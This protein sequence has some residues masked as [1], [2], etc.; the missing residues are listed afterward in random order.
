VRVLLVITD[1]PYYAG[2]GF[3][4]AWTQTLERHGCEVERLSGIPPQWALDGPPADRWQLA[5][6]HVL[7][8]EVA[9]F[10]PTMQLASLLESA[11]VPLLNRLRSIVT[12]ADKLATHAAWAAHDLPQPATVPLDGI[13]RWPRPGRR[14]VLK[15]ALGDGARHIAL[16]G[17]LDEARAIAAAWRADERRGGERRGR[18]L[19]QEWIEEPTC[20]R[21]YATPNRTSLA[22][23]KDRRPGALVTHGTVYPRV[24]T[25]PRA[26]AD[27]ARRMVATLGGGLMGVDVLTD[28]DGRHWALEAN[29]P[30]G[31]DITDRGQANF[32]AAAALDRIRP[33]V[34]GATDTRAFVALAA[35]SIRNRR[36]R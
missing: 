12:S 11:R 25:P 7:V 18:A 34:S 26:M 3:A 36:R 27:L 6:P 24:H 23:E 2:T 14:M 9:A 35:G 15:P 1:S 16:V 22:Y 10:A 5:I 20:T 21:L 33:S 19:L 13:E 29:A 8:E 28:A 31:F 32:L 17:D 4:G 30:F